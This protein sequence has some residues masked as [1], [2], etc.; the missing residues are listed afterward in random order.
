MAMG[1]GET[2]HRSPRNGESFRIKRRAFHLVPPNGGLLVTFNTRYKYGYSVAT[3][4]I[5]LVTDEL[6][7]KVF[8]TR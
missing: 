1:M 3:L 2:I 6:N 8:I 7:L 5:K 4:G